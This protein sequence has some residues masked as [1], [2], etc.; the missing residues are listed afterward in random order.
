MDAN[1]FA[2]DFHRV[3]GLLIIAAAVAG[4]GVVGL[5]WWIF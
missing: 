1:S 2:R 5:I 4:G 3:I